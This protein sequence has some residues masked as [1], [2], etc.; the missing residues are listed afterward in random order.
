MSRKATGF[1]T[2]LA[3]RRALGRLTQDPPRIMRTRQAS[4]VF[5]TEPSEGAPS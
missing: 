1:L 2:R 4:S 3:E 5:H